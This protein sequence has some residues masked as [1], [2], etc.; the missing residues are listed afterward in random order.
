MSI[1]F[2]AVF[3]FFSQVHTHDDLDSSKPAL[4]SKSD[5]R[6]ISEAAIVVFIMSS[7]TERSHFAFKELLLVAWLDKPI[8]TAVF[9]NS[10]NDARYSMK[11]ILGQKPAINFTRN[12]YLEGLEVL[13]YHVT[14]SQCQTRAIFQQQYVQNMRDGVKSLESLVS[15]KTGTARF[16]LK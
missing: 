9:K 6:Y 4:H 2:N 13:R 16:L 15:N 5:A 12:M 1:F 8:I 10:W 14:P 3:K 7:S 11:A